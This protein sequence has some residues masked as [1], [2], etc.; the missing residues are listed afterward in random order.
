ML[1]HKAKNCSMVGLNHC[2]MQGRSPAAPALN[3]IAGEDLDKFLLGM[4]SR[5]CA[6][7]G[8]CYEEKSTITILTVQPQ[9]SSAPPAQPQ[10]STAFRHRRPTTTGDFSDAGNS[11]TQ[12]A[13]LSCQ[14]AGVALSCPRP[15]FWKT[16]QKPN[17]WQ[18]LQGALQQ[19]YWQGGHFRQ[20]HLSHFDSNPKI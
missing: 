9:N 10:N 11:R 19:N 1:L 20:E 4:I 8:R 18:A 6:T 16:F 5:I 3:M 15:N 2:Y 12:R 7:G 13:A 14:D 17:Y